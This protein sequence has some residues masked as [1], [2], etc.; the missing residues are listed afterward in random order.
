MR[1]YFTSVVEGSGA[2]NGTSN[3]PR[4]TRR[5]CSKTAKHAWNRPYVTVTASKA[6]PNVLGRRSGRD[7]S[8][9]EIRRRFNGVATIKRVDCASWHPKW[10]G[11]PV[12]DRDRGASTIVPVLEAPAPD[13]QDN[14]RRTA[15]GRKSRPTA[16]APRDVERRG[17]GNAISSTRVMS[18]AA[19]PP[20]SESA[21]PVVGRRW[22][23]CGP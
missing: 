10:S 5:R 18:A 15:G 19:A 21:V 2:G 11:N 7:P 23:R 3:K 20:A 14:V 9:Y 12:P 16:I 4:E 6:P 13:R 8:R 1:L 22:V 17:V